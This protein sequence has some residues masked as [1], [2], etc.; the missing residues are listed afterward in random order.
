MIRLCLLEAGWDFGCVI[1]TQAAWQQSGT[2]ALLLSA[3]AEA[4]QQVPIHFIWWQQLLG[5]RPVGL[6]CALPRHHTR[7]SH[8][9]LPST[10]PSTQTHP[11]SMVTVFIAVLSR[12]TASPGSMLQAVPVST[13]IFVTRRYT[14]A[15]STINK[16]L[17][18]SYVGTKRLCADFVGGHLND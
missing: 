8:S 17:R 5:A 9:T 4:W 2:S 10:P 15:F 14:V 16:R 11:E 7:P 18:W 1:R 6:H 13:T 12:A 3:A